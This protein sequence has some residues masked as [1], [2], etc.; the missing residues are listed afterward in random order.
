MLDQPARMGAI[1][2]NHV[3]IVPVPAEQQNEVVQQLL[4]ATIT[5]A[6]FQRCIGGIGNED[7]GSQRSLRPRPPCGFF[8][9]ATQA[10]LDEA[11]HPERTQA[12][13]QR[14]NDVLEEIEAK[15]ATKVGRL[16][17]Q[18]GCRNDGVLE[19]VHRREAFSH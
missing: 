6:S 2:A 13:S 3:G 7:R 17:A 14:I 19:K 12:I 8:V 16:H 10:I 5:V 15:T 4:A 1:H 18:L 11:R 9:A